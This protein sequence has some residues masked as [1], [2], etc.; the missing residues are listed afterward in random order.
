MTR[1]LKGGFVRIT[2]KYASRCVCGQEIRAREAVYW[3][4]ELKLVRCSTCG[5]KSP[6]ALPACCLCGRTRHSAAWSP[7]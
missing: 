4:P 6:A 2:A 3:H 5:P 7:A 1:K